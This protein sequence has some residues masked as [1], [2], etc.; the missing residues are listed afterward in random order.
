M[1][2]DFLAF[3][4][5]KLCGPTGI[6]VMYGKYEL[7]KD[8]PPLLSGG[9]MNTRFDTCGDI[10]LQKPPLKFEAGTQNI[11]GVLGLEAAIKYIEK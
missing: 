3:S 6:G 7:L 8:M 1:D 5:H 11:A 4:G 9:G 2:C 10:L